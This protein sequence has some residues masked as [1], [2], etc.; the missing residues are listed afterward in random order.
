MWYHICDIYVCVCMCVCIYIYTHTH[1]NIYVYIYT[2]IFLKRMANIHKWTKKVSNSQ[3][4]TWTDKEIPKLTKEFSFDNISS[5]VYHV[6]WIFIR[7]LK[8][9]GLHVIWPITYINV[10]SI[11]NKYIFQKELR[12]MIALGL[13]EQN[14]DPF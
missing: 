6:K 2:C 9:N 12:K 5:C 14:Q 13:S 7:S 11:K 10:S 1:M 8:A 4:G 3:S